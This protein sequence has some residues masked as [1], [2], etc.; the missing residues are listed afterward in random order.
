MVSNDG[1]GTG[2]AHA[3]DRGS[4]PL[5][6]PALHRWKASLSG[7]HPHLAGDA[8][9]GVDSAAGVAGRGRAHILLEA[10]V[11]PELYYPLHLNLIAHGRAICQARRPRCEMCPLKAECEYYQERASNYEGG[12]SQL[13]P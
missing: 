12:N 5:H 6:R 13:V 3:R 10:R 7:G 2:C 11:P 1:A 9:V 8:T 4:D